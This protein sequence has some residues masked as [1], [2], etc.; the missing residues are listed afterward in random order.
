MF[1]YSPLLCSR[2]GLAGNKKETRDW[3]GNK[4]ETQEQVPESP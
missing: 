3:R 1:S 4:K 2:G